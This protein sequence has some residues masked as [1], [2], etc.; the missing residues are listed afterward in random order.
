MTRRTLLTGFGAS[1]AVGLGAKQVGDWDE[2]S[3]RARV[4]IASANSYETELESVISA[5]I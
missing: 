3:N 5:G 4:F 2:W 1:V